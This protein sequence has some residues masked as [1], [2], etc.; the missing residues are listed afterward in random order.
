MTINKKHLALVGFL[1]S[2]PP[3]YVWVKWTKAFVFTGDAPQFEKATAFLN[4]LPVIL[5]NTSLLNIISQGFPLIAIIAGIVSLKGM[6]GFFKIIAIVA[7]VL[8]ILFTSVTFL[9]AF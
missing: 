7:I 4:S 1:L 6:Y 9:V 5:Q 3:M 2:L 8:G